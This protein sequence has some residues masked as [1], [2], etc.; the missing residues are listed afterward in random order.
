MAANPVGMMKPTWL[1]GVIQKVIDKN[2]ATA[3]AQAIANS[4]QLVDAIKKGLA[5]KPE[6][7][8]MGPSH[9]QN[10]R[11]AVVEALAAD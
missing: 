4:P 3:I 6:P 1:D 9:A 8:V 7:G 10:I 2:D 5:N 11:K